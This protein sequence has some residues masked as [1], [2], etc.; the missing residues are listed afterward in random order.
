MI[1]SSVYFIAAAG[2]IK[3]GTT[4]DLLRRFKALQSA[5]PESLTVLAAIPGDRA[6]EAALHE[7]LMAYRVRLE[8][9]KD[10]A[11]VREAMN[12]ALSERGGQFLPDPL[13]YTTPTYSPPPEPPA[14][15]DILAIVGPV[16]CPLVDTITV[17]SDRFTRLLNA[18][19]IQ[20]AEKDDRFRSALQVVKK[21]LFRFGEITDEATLRVVDRNMFGIEKLCIRSTKLI[22]QAENAFAYLFPHRA[23]AQG[24][25]PGGR[26]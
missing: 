15:K 12:A 1:N 6:V 7:S 19:E 9:F 18:P 22:E 23:M 26:R 21:A 2:H 16:G 10:C 5:N 3:I 24:R 13:T 4:T 20:G 14:P 17:V 8:W 11:E 25:A